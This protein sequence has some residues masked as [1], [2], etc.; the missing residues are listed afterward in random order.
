M[1]GEERWLSW[2]P[3]GSNP[4]CSTLSLLLAAPADVPVGRGLGG[5][6]DVLCLI[7]CLDPH[8]VCRLVE[9]LVGGL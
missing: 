3:S 4:L 9:L 5:A 7:I 1:G 2:D 6:G 8:P